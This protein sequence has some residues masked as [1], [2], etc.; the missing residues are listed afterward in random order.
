MDKFNFHC[1]IYPEQIASRA[2]RGISDFYNIDMDRDGTPETL[3]KE[4][5]ECGI[6]RCLVHSVAT[7]PHQV[8]RI[9]DFISDECKKHKEFT[10]FGTIHADMENPEEE[11]NRIIS[12]GLQ[13]IKIHPDTQ[14]FNIDCDNMKK[15]YEIIAG[16]LPI[17]IHCG[18]YRYDYSH[19]RRLAKIID[20]FPKLTVIGAHFGGW[21]LQDLAL[22]YLKDRK[23]YI[24]TSSSMMFLGNVRSR[25]LIKA[26]GAERVLFGTD[27]PM[28]R[29]KDE[30]E[31]IEKLNLSNEEL[32]LIY[33]D[34]GRRILGEI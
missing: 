10:G 32:Q 7:A 26:Y 15:I 8:Q 27:F 28:W 13:G 30:V 19:P 24:D 20:E 33:M 14:L 16:R 17:L 25:E 23:C 18:D 12:L 3:L 31:M 21:S 11:I 4:S 9:N 34:N 2:V 5:K 6:T 1:H 22:E 29:A